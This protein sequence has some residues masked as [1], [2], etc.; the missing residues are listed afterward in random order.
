MPAE[1][2]G[3]LS[4]VCHPQEAFWSNNLILYCH[5]DDEGNVSGRLTHARGSVE[6][7]LRYEI[8]GNDWL[9]CLMNLRSFLRKTTGTNWFG[10]NA[11]RR[12]Y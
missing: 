7:D 3:N 2:E 8:N 4:T 9:K 10:E 12:E 5:R 11:E 6:Y 1:A